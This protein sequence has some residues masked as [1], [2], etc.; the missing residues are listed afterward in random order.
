MWRSTFKITVLSVKRNFIRYG[1]RV[2]ARSSKLAHKSSSNFSSSAKREQENYYFFGDKVSEK[3]GARLVSLVENRIK[4]CHF[5]ASYLRPDW[6]LLPEPETRSER[7]WDSLD[8]T[9]RK[10]RSEV[11]AESENVETEADR[12]NGERM[13]KKMCVPK[14]LGT[15]YFTELSKTVLRFWESILSGSITHK[16]IKI[17][18]TQPISFL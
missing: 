11:C 18:A 6:G 16:P 8:T 3:P 12:K 15:N 1:F 2:G 7:C 9:M 17:T 14:V 13:S 5:G 4:W 10:G